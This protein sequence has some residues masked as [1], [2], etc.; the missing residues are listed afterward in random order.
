MPTSESVTTETRSLKKKRTQEKFKEML[1]RQPAKN[2]EEKSQKWSSDKRSNL[3]EA[4]TVT[5]SSEQYNTT[6]T[7]ETVRNMGQ[8][9]ATLKCFSVM[10]DH[11]ANLQKHKKLENK[12][13]LL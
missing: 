2:A 12:L 10:K 4:P 8:E 9:F 5:S 11:L 13:G 6:T 7:I 3:T 1:F